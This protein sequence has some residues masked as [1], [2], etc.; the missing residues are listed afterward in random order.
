MAKFIKRIRTKDGDKQIDYE[1]IGNPPNIPKEI[2]IDPTFKVEG[3]AADAKLT[4]DVLGMFA[5]GLYN[6]LNNIHA[7]INKEKIFDNTPTCDVWNLVWEENFDGNTLDEKTWNYNVGKDK[8][9]NN[10]LEYYT[11][12]DNLTVE[13]GCLVIT[14]KKETDEALI[15]KYGTAYTS[16]RITTMKK[17]SAKYGRVEARIK[18]PLGQGLWPAFWMMGSANYYAWPACGEIDIMEHLNSNTKISAALHGYSGKTDDPLHNGY[19]HVSYGDKW[20]DVPTPDDFHIYAFEWDATT[21]KWYV[22]D[23]CFWTY[24]RDVN[25]EYQWIFDEPFYIILNVAIGGWP[26]NPNDEIFPK[27]MYVDYV[28]VYAKHNIDTR[29]DRKLLWSD[30]FEYLDSSKWNFTGDIFEP[31]SSEQRRTD[32]TTTLCCDS[33]LKLTMYKSNDRLVVPYM[34]SKQ[35]FRHCLIEI[36]ANIGRIDDNSSSIVFSSN[37]AKPT[38]NDGAVDFWGC[39]D[40][41]IE[42]NRTDNNKIVYGF[43]SPDPKNIRRYLDGK[44]IDI[45]Y[46]DYNI[47]GFEFLGSKIDFYINRS[48]VF[49]IPY[50]Y[51]A[52]YKDVNVFEEIGVH[53][54]LIGRLYNK[55]IDAAS[56]TPTSMF[57][58]WVKVYAL[59]G[60]KETKPTHVNMYNIDGTKYLNEPYFRLKYFPETAQVLP[61][62]EKYVNI[63]GR[64]KDGVTNNAIFSILTDV[65]NVGNT[66]G[67]MFCKKKNITSDDSPSYM[68]INNYEHF[69]VGETSAINLILLDAIPADM[70]PEEYKELYEETKQYAIEF[71]FEFISGATPTTLTIAGAKNMFTPKAN[72][73]YLVHVIDGYVDYI[74][75]DI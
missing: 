7:A 21:M 73:R 54:G 65:G 53:I 1:A 56:E 33:I 35:G 3:Q 38:D 66:S 29:V 75:T 12:G 36:K 44:V 14:A 47:Y 19:V 40:G 50:T 52:F 67:M 32:D 69:T 16:S 20:F 10:E 60:E 62:N 64:A 24:T 8:W 45:P 9:G 27:S 58:D 41:F 51:F 17:V 43:A 23:V 6:E 30:D 13:D 31:T 28:K 42:L 5:S 61:G 49:S 68:I 26:G 57:V 22:D 18:L 15:E 71:R 4:G 39:P 25:D 46:D 63:S 37:S 34:A 72:K 70:I 74:E 11:E 55:N 59:D 2:K 48:L